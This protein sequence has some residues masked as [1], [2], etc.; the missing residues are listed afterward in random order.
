MEKY[1]SLLRRIFDYPEVLFQVTAELR[2]NFH[3][4]RVSI[5]F[6]DRHGLFVS[7]L[8]EGLEGMDLVFKPGEGI[9]GKCVLNKQAIIANDPQHNPQTLSRV[10]DHYTGYHTA[11]LLAAPILTSWKRVVGAV[12]LVNKREGLFTAED[13]RR[14]MEIAPLL[15]GLRRRV[16][17]PISN[18]WKPA[19]ARELRRA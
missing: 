7:A 2:K 16:P 18:I 5:F 19:L 17:R 10:R 6:K 15:K 8:A 13:A 14:L 1:R 4:D 9:V 12:E 11:S 3:C